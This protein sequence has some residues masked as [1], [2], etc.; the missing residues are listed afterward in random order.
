MDFYSILGVSKGVDADVIKKAYRK[1][2]L[3]NHPDKGGDAEKF[4]QISEAYAVLS[5][6]EKRS[7]YDRF[8]PD[9]EKKG[10]EPNMNMNHMNMPHG[11]SMNDVFG[12]LFR[13]AGQQQGQAVVSRETKHIISLP[14]LDFYK[15]KQLKRSVSRIAKCSKCEG[16]GGKKVTEKI[17]IPC[18]GKGF[19][20]DS[21]NGGFAMFQTRKSCQACSSTGKSKTIHG[22]CGNCKATGKVSERVI[23]EPVIKPGDSPGTRYVFPGMGNYTGNSPSGDVVIVTTLENNKIFI[24]RG[25]DIHVKKELTLKESLTGFNLEVEHIDGRM[26][27]INS[28]EGRVTPP[29]TIIRIPGEGI[30]QNKGNLIITISVKFPQ[31]ISKLTSGILKDIH[32]I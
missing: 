4:K 15:G 30:P 31:T 7:K 12:N 18:E 16:K 22:P 13:G 23:I 10:M 20:V 26:I 11:F 14:L 5:D 3:K 25:S 27:P 9:F 6:P 1:L 32:D 29:G 19:T 8:G 21:S 28:N 17:C 24:R 2:A